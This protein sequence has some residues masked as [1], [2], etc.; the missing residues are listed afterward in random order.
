MVLARLVT[1][2]R[3][4]FHFASA[5]FPAYF[6]DFEFRHA[7]VRDHRAFYTQRN[8]ANVPWNILIASL[9]GPRI[10]RG[11]FSSVIFILMDRLNWD[12]GR[13]SS[14]KLGFA[15][16]MWRRRDSSYRHPLPTAAKLIRTDAFSLRPCGCC[17][18]SGDMTRMSY[19]GW[20]GPLPTFVTFRSRKPLAKA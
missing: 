5:A 10:S 4:K 14:A 19:W 11:T 13:I 8:G 1:R 16:P 17:C 12:R 15:A 18:K 7:T 3:A 2:R 6:L 9:K 20:K